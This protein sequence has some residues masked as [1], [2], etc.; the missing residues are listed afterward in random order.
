MQFKIQIV[1]D[2]K[3]G[4]TIT[5]DILT[6]DKSSDGEGLVGL[7][8]SE[9]KR[10]LKQLQKTIV[11]QQADRYTQAHRCC[12]LC[13]KKQRIKDSY[14]IQYRTLFGIIPIPNLRLFLCQCTKQSTKTYSVLNGWLPEHN[15]PELQ[16]IETKWASLMSYGITVDLLT[17]VLPVNECLNAETVRRHVHKTAKRQDERLKDQPRFI[18]GCQYEWAN[19]P[20]P[21]KPLTVGID[22]GYVRDCENKK[23]NFEV[24]VAKSFSKTEAP[25]RLGFVQ[26]LDAKPQR[27]MMKLLRD[28]GMQENQQITFLSDGADNVRDLQFLMHPESEHILDWFHATMRL[29]VLNQFAKGMCHTDPDAGAELLEKLDSAKWYLWHGNV[30]QGLERLDDCY[31]LCDDPELRYDKRRKL[32]QHLSDMITYIDN[33]SHL[34]PNYG[35]KYRN[36]E[37]IT[38][39]F[40]ESTVNEVVAKRMV[41]KQQM[42]WSRQGAHCLLQTRT[43]VLN[44]ELRD[45]F[46]EW[47]PEMKV[48][49]H[50][51]DYLEPVKLAA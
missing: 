13:H 48:G 4:E 44:G 37:T 35:E 39:A 29:T 19:L 34:I 40:V 11:S 2:D 8:L 27:R 12:P 20:K 31:C 24:I 36:G 49:A 5:E 23:T 47:Y 26:A 22:G 50:E 30:E 42:Q 43:A 28:Q 21:G 51:S 17:D 10:V 41:K 45:H 46:E 14:D 16:Y 1:V 38:T 25:K 9:S 32:V 7:S 3:H 18:S 6:L 33:N 15:S